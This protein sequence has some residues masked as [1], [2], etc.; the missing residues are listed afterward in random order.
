MSDKLLTIIA[1]LSSVVA[2]L[3]LIEPRWIEAVVGLDPDG[4]TG[5]FEWLLVAALAASA[6]A[7]ARAAHRSHM[8]RRSHTGHIAKEG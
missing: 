2:T 6:I 8:R 1:A 4:G 3:T 7:L 5:A